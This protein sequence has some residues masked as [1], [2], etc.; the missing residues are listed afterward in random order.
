MMNNMY[1]IFFMGVKFNCKINDYLRDFGYQAPTKILPSRS[2][3]RYSSLESFGTRWRKYLCVSPAAVEGV[4]ERND[5]SQF[6]DRASVFHTEISIGPMELSMVRAVAMC[7]E[8][9]MGYEYTIGRCEYV[10]EAYRRTIGR[11]SVY[12]HLNLTV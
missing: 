10:G 2:R 6:E 3:G 4:T 9:V 5:V 7:I 8:R 11:L 12:C 1:I